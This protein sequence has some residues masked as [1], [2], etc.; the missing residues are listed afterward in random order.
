MLTHEQ[1]ASHPNSIDPGTP[2]GQNSCLD[3]LILTKDGEWLVVE[4]EY[5][6][7]AKG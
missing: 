5:F 3:F 6:L 4:A 1:S 7:A 2:P